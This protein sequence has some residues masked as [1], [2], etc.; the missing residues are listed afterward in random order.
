MVDLRGPR[1]GANVTSPGWSEA[2]PRVCGVILWSP[3]GGQL[4]SGAITVAVA[5][6][7]LGL[8]PDSA[9]CIPNCQTQ[10]TA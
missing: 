3:N 8:L 1:E 9:R 7:R 10:A 6:A 4:G 2:E 5:H